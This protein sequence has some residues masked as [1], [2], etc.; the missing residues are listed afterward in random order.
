VQDLVLDIDFRKNLL[1]GS[2]K[3]DVGFPDSGKVLDCAEIGGFFKFFLAPRISNRVIVQSS[4]FCIRSF[5]NS[6][7]TIYN[8]ML[9]DIKRA[10]NDNFR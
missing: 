10:N 5:I 3:K 1:F 8:F 4:L 7:S 9:L 6:R 2:D